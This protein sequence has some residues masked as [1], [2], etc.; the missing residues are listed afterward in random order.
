M[1]GGRS[2]LKSPLQPQSSPRHA[3][4]KVS[5]IK[6]TRD[7]GVTGL[8]R[9]AWDFPAFIEGPVAQ[10]N[11]TVG[12]PNLGACWVEAQLRSPTPRV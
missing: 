3:R 10:A 1:G 4:L 7:T 12:H 5:L 11:Q 6:V 2:H 9:F 8:P